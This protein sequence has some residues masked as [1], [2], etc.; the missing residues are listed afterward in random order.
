MTAPGRAFA[1]SLADRPAEKPIV[2]ADP[3]RGNFSAARAGSE[4][5]LAA[6]ARQLDEASRHLAAARDQPQI[7]GVSYATARR[8]VERV[9]AEIPTASKELRAEL[10]VERQEIRELPPAYRDAASLAAQHSVRALDRVDRAHENLVA[11]LRAEPHGVSRL[12]A[13]FRGAHRSDALAAEVR[14]ASLALRSA[15]E[16]LAAAR[17]VRR[18]TQEMVPTE[19]A[20]TQRIDAILTDLETRAAR[21]PVYTNGNGRTDRIGRNGHATHDHSV[22]RPD[23]STQREASGSREPSVARGAPPHS[24]LMSTMD[25]L[26]QH[27]RAAALRH[28]VARLETHAVRE[29]HDAVARAADLNARVDRA[30]A[31]SAAFDQAL[32]RVY[33]DPASAREAFEVDAALRGGDVAARALARTPERYGS[34]ATTERRYALGLVVTQ[35]TRDAKVAA[36]EAAERGRLEVEA[37]RMAP[38][39]AELTHGRTA[40]QNSVFH[41]DRARQV[42]ARLPSERQLS[43]EV[44]Q[45]AKRM[46]P[47]EFERFAAVASAAQL[48]LVARIRTNVRAMALGDPGMER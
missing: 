15:H 1:D 14:E 7:P 3:A 44:A 45:A 11:T 31:H 9:V 27:E 26:A 39:A 30:Q 28:A 34:L 46:T 19:R 41:E 40:L 23:A 18:L 36:P 8:T 33:R 21:D 47:Q 2:N 22:P 38:S 37:A 25:A 10:K 5:R 48:A 32:A 6:L 4:E 42:A 13:P 35:S 16:E 12:A 20:R 17:D 24:A 43:A 29:V